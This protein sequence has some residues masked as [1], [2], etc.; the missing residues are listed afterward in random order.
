MRTLPQNLV[1]LARKGLAPIGIMPDGKKEYAEIWGCALHVAGSAVTFAL[2]RSGAY[3]E[4]PPS[5]EAVWESLTD[6]D[7]KIFATPITSV[8]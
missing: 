1:Y 2:A 3:A 8:L 6:L 5:L 7:P 4:T